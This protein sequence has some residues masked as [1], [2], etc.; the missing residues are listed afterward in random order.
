M[1]HINTKDI[2]LVETRNCCVWTYVIF[3][4]ARIT[5]DETD[6]SNVRKWL[7][8]LF[9]RLHVHNQLP[10]SALHVQAQEA[11]I[12]DSKTENLQHIRKLAQRK[13]KVRR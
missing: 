2:Q 13:P 6:M 9:I 12:S 5:F 8:T 10:Y 4:S 1:G 7:V 3:S 11:R